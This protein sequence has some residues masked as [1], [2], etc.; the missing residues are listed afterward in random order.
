M[1]DS[2]YVS[3]QTCLDGTVDHLCPFGLDAGKEMEGDD[4]VEHSPDGISVLTE[5]ECR[6]KFPLFDAV[7]EDL[8]D[9]VDGFVC[10]FDDVAIEILRQIH[11]GGMEHEGHQDPEQFAIAQKEV[12]IDGGE[13][14]ERFGRTGGGLKNIGD[15]IVELVDIAQQDLRIDLFLAV[16]IKVN[17]P[18]AQLCFFGDALHRDRFETL[19]EKKLPGRL[20]DG[21]F[22]ILAFP[23]SSLFQS[24]DLNPS[25][26]SC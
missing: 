7:F 23:L 10:G 12:D 20:E 15:A 6:G 26:Q 22:P 18:F 17:G 24:Q 14:Q 5:I 9:N 1:H 4:A 3:V 11:V 8:F 2:V 19:V 13:A 21:I 25:W 16:V